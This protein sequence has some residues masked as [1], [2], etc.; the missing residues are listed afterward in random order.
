MS[1]KIEISG[2]GEVNFVKSK[3]A[4]RLR[5]SI[6][7]FKGVRVSLPYFMSYKSALRFVMEKEQWIIDHSESMSQKLEGLT[8]FDEYTEF[9]TNLHEVVIQKTTT[10]VEPK[11]VMF[12]EKLNIKFPSGVDLK[13]MENQDFIRRAIE[14]S[15]RKEAKLVLPKRT[16]ELAQQFDFTYGKVSVRNTKSR[17][18][19]CSFHNN[20]S[21]SLHLMRLPE[22]LRD[23]VI[24]HE[25][26]HTQQK[27]HQPP[28][29]NLLDTVTEGKAKLLD[30][31]L[32][33]FSTR[34]Y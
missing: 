21:L 12:S 2:I 29:W 19:S 32:K 17:W 9:K 18:G 25:L 28:F 14:E 27:N 20:I 5:I 4:K 11:A 34:I 13:E 30:K 15:W 6:N 10:V 23:Y 22:K 8:L 7:P 24:L 1:K 16:E 3:R 33:Q 26:A 31:E